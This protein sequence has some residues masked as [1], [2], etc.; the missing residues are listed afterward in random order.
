MHFSTHQTVSIG[1]SPFGKINTLE[2]YT[3]SYT[4]SEFEH[5][6][7]DHASK[8]ASMGVWIVPQGNAGFVYSSVHCY[9]R[10]E[11]AKYLKFAGDTKLGLHPSVG[12]DT[13]IYKDEW[14]GTTVICESV[15]VDYDGTN[16]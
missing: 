15:L 14:K 1:N 10:R 13:S 12:I 3:G 2:T 16:C 5:K 4:G 7:I 9:E 11:S 6:V 8:F